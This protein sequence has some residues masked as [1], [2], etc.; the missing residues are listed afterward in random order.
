MI[1]NRSG[2]FSQLSPPS[3]LRNI[4]PL[5][6]LIKRAPSPPVPAKIELESS[7]SN[8]MHSTMLSNGLGSPLASCSHDAPPSR[9]RINAPLALVGRL[10]HKGG[11]SSAT[12]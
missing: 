10:S 1:G 7:G 5:V 11:G 8:S 6:S 9:L 3:A 12:P 2:T 4:S